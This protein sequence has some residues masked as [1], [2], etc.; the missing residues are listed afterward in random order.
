[1]GAT[2]ARAPEASTGD[3]PDLPAPDLPPPDIGNDA[4]CSGDAA[5]SCYSGP[6]GTQGVGLCQAGTQLCAGGLWGPC[7][8][9]VTPKPEVCDELDN[10]CN[11]KPDDKLVC[12]TTLAGKGHSYQD[13]PQAKASF[14]TPYQVALDA[15]GDLM[16]ADS[17]N[18]RVRK[19]SGG[20]VFTIAGSGKI[21]YKDGPALSALFSGPFDLA[22]GPAG[23][24]YI[25]DTGNRRIRKLSGGQVT[26]VAGSGTRGSM[27]GPA[28][29]ASFDTPWGLSMDPA[30]ALYIADNTGCQ[31]RRLHNGK[32]TT[33]AGT[34]SV[35]HLDGL[36]KTAQF[37]HP[38]DV[39]WGG[40]NTLYVSDTANH[41]VRR[42]RW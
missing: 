4:S 37:A 19:I 21:G 7:V 33:V 14:N 8:G 6:S 24:I 9:A 26:T 39:L 11:S 30:G 32:V 3:A 16:V 29:S 25:A 15:A 17:S 18:F 35:G 28:L 1:M 12:V 5:R 31:V 38:R 23:A 22:L 13:G 36:G 10:D 42:I 27:D 34:T 40:A 41:R 2:D 20:K